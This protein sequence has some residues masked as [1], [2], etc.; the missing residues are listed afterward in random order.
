MKQIQIYKVNF[1]TIC[2][3]HFDLSTYIL[4]SSEIL[5]TKRYHPQRTFGDRRKNVCSARTYFYSGEEKCDQN[6]EVFLKLVRN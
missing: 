3:N 2:F 5:F 4:A 1:Q 6:M